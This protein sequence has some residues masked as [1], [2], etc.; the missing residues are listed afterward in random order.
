D[1]CPALRLTD[2]A[3]KRAALDLHLSGAEHGHR[4]GNVHIAFRIECSPFECAV[5]G[6]TYAEDFSADEVH[7]AAL[8]GIGLGLCGGSKHN[9]TIGVSATAA[10]VDHCCVLR[11][12]PVSLETRGWRCHG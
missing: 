3:K 11:I 10:H 7:R 4:R 2:Q 9:G 1:L 8:A 12:G 5:A 6:G